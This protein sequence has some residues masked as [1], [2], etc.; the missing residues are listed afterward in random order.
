MGLPGISGIAGFM[1]DITLIANAVGTA[2][3]ITVPT[4]GVGG[5][6][7]PGDYA[8][9]FDGV[10]DGA[11]G[12]IT[13]VTPS[14]W[15]NLVNKYTDFGGDSLRCMVSRKVLVS[16]DI[17]SSIT[18][19][20]PK[21]YVR[22]HIF[23]FRTNR[24][25]ST[26]TWQGEVNPPPAVQTVTASSQLNPTIVFG[27][28]MIR[29]TSGN[30]DFNTESPAFS[31]KVFNAVNSVVGYKIYMASPQNHSVGTPGDFLASGFASFS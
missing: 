2:T 18:G 19:M 12:S 3:S 7:L 4:S 22:K 20:A 23:V 5:P 1:N 15:N 31:T 26:E 6:V 11:G 30:P 9:M 10:F 29:S 28:A 21:N 16:G 14:G 25:V 24:N 17:G 13:A 27:F 8:I